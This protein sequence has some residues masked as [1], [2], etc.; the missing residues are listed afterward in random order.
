MFQD[1]YDKT[2]KYIILL[3]ILITFCFPTTD[4]TWVLYASAPSFP[5]PYTHTFIFMCLDTVN[6]RKE[7]KKKKISEKDLR[8]LFPIPVM[9][10]PCLFCVSKKGTWMHILFWIEHISAK[11][12]P[13][14]LWRIA[15]LFV[16]F[17]SKSVM[18]W[19]SWMRSSWAGKTVCRELSG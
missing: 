7:E 13:R 8:P 3:P 2:I 14:S 17:Y 9:R 16:R 19:M 1:N 12:S 15:V 4:P 10:H 5:T 11:R 18:S 6:L